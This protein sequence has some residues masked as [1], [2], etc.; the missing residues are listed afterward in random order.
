MGRFTVSPTRSVDAL[1][2]LDGE[3]RR[4]HAQGVAGGRQGGEEETS[5]TVRYRCFSQAGLRILDGQIGPAMA[6]PEGS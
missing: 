2:I 1:Q 6:A 5:I 3:A 4:L